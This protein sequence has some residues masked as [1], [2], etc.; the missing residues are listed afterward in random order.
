MTTRK[1]RFGVNKATRAKRLIKSYEFIISCLIGI[2][3]S[4]IFLTQ[5]KA[6]H[7]CCNYDNLLS[8]ITK[9]FQSDHARMKLLNKV[10]IASNV[11]NQN[12]GE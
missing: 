8:L 3:E 4:R 9:D 1:I 6:L 12:P 2:L 5:I 11:I 7:Y 10:F